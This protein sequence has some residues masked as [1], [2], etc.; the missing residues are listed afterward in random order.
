MLRTFVE[1]P[2]ELPREIEV[3]RAGQ[4]THTWYG[5]IVIT[6]QDLE[7]FVANFNERILN[8]D[9]PFDISHY[10]NNEGAP[11]WV[12]G[13]RTDGAALYAE[14]DWTDYGERLVM[15][16]RYRYVS[17]EFYNVYRRPTDNKRFKNVLSKI[18]L[19][20]DPFFKELTPITATDPANTMQLFTDPGG[21][22]MPDDTKTT[23]TSPT[24]P[25]A[26]A[27][28]PTGEGNGVTA[29]APAPTSGVT[30][31]Q[32]EAMQAENRRM[33][34]RLAAAEAQQAETARQLAVKE[35]TDRFA[36]MRFGANGKPQFT[37]AYCDKLAT[38]ALS[39]SAENGSDGQPIRGEDGAPRTDGEGKPVR[40]ERE[41][42]VADMQA[43]A[44]A[45]V[46]RG[47]RAAVVAGGGGDPT[48]RY[49][50]AVQ[51]KMK[52]DPTLT[53]AEAC[54]LVNGEQPELAGEALGAGE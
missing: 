2:A 5:E 46:E 9:I 44:G 33:A 15:N 20:N 14:V 53:H 31:Q 28:L 39:V 6:A 13:L 45:I 23:A 54:K 35:L 51:A 3:L 21:S 19:T 12:K 24:P 25:A 37:P 38:W 22:S 36:E 16:R 48:E 7:Q 10:D 17:P 41:E 47:Q 30:A 1:L 42:F 34:E 29:T 27:P 26:P 43:L 50:A 49:E 52:G 4:W 40:S 18:A 11:A 8:R 32:F